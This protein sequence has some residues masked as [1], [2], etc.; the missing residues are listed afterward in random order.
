MFLDMS[1]RIWTMVQILPG[2]RRRAR[3]PL[4]RPMERLHALI[5]KGVSTRV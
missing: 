4:L 1:K 3:Q 5:A 2:E